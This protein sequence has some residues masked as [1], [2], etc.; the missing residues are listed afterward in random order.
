MAVDILAA[1]DIW[2]R[3]EPEAWGGRCIE[4][5]VYGLSRVEARGLSRNGGGDGSTGFHAA[6]AIRD[7]GTLHYG[8]DYGGKRWDK[9]LSGTEERT[10]GRDGLPS[11]LEP[12]AAQHKVAEVTLVRGFSDCAKAI[13]NGYPVYLC[14][15]R[16]FSMTFKRDAKYGGGWLTPMGTWAHCLMACDLRWDRPALR[17]PN[18]WG[19]C[20]DGPVDDKAP[21]AFQRTSGWVDASVIDSMCAGG[22]S[23]AVAGFNGFRP[24]LMPENWLD[25]VL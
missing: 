11:N 3:R 23:Y 9:Q 17:V 10:L 1:C 6:K 24:S 14:S 8:Q 25:G 2:L 19:D 16:G 18:S 20:Y 12:Y 4:G 21:P 5:V 7:F 15:M 13:S 22:D